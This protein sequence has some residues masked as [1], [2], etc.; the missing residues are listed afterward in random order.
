MISRLAAPLSSESGRRAADLLDERRVAMHLALDFERRA[1]AREQARASRILRGRAARRSCRN[2]NATAAPPCGSMPKRRTAPRR[3][4][5][6][7]A[8]C[9]AV[10]SSIDIGVAEEERA[11]AA[12]SAHERRRSAA[13]PARSPMTSTMCAGGDDTGRPRRTA[14]ASASPRCTISAAITRRRVRTSAA[15]IIGRHA[16]AL[17]QAV[18]GVQYSR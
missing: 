16:L 10:G 1:R 4:S 11:L 15:R 17:H 13:T 5:V 9:S 18:I 3:S 7:S 12:A 6:I 2:S 8:S 14:C